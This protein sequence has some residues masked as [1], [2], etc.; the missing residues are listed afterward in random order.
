VGGRVVSS[1]P[2]RAWLTDAFAIRAVSTEADLATLPTSGCWALVSGHWDG[3]RLADARVEQAWHHPLPRGD[4]EQQRFAWRRIALHLQVRGRALA[5]I[6]QWFSDSGFVEVQTPLRVSA[7]GLDAEIEPVPA[8]G[9]WLVTSPEHHMKR[10]LVGGMPRIFEVARASRRE[11]LGSLHQ[12]EFTLI[13]WYR[14]FAEPDQVMQDVEQLVRM[15]VG[16]FFGRSTIEYHGRQ[17]D[18]S[19]PFARLSVKDA[20]SRHAEIIDVAQVAED[21]PDRYQRLLVERV[22]P[23]LADYGRGVWLVDYPASHAA[24]ARRL[25]GN[26][27]YADRF[28]LYLAG[29]E[30]CNGYGELTDANEQRSRFLTEL[31]TRERTGR[32][33]YPLDEPFLDALEE[34]LPPCSGVALGFDR[35]VMLALGVDDIADVVAFPFAPALPQS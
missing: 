9:G 25:P 32:P 24:L 31:A 13:E 22:E 3:E 20:F 11:E 4:G 35:L 8:E 23:A 21:D 18:L 27:A 26:E 30:L 28:E 34:G 15:V 1:D 5:A 19:E 29:V 10:L 16:L 17:L 6:R 33:T 7:P 12:P 14:A 2:D